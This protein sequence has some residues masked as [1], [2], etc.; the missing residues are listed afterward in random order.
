MAKK[1]IGWVDTIYYL[2]KWRKSILAVIL[3]VGILAA[4]LSPILPRWY[5]ASATLMPPVED[6]G[7][8]SVSSFVSKYAFSGG[9]LGLGM[10]SE[11]TSLLI[12]I[13]QS[14]IMMEAV[15]SEHDLISRYKSKNMEEAVRTLRDRTS[16]KVNEEGTITLSVSARTKILGGK[17]QADEAR[18]LARDMADTFIEKLDEINK[19]L[20]V[21]RARNTRIFI[22][23]RYQQNREDLR[24]AEETFK[25]Y[26]QKYG[27]IALNEQATATINAAAD[28]KTQIIAK[29]V[30]TGWLKNVVGQDHSEYLRAES[31][32]RVLEDKYKQFQYGKKK[33]ARGGDTK[34]DLF[35]P[36]ED[37]PELGI[38]YARLYRE[39]LMQEK[40]ME[41]LLPEFEQAKINEA[42]DTPTVQVLDNAVIPVAKSKPKRALFV[43]IAVMTALILTFVMILIYERIHMLQE[44]DR[45][46]YERLQEALRTVKTD[47]KLHKRKRIL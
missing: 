35:L 32:L 39:V 28:F 17:A 23:T 2:V 9:M 16:T 27:T 19:S 46:K 10:M 21:D 1:E 13:L 33:G 5:T 42:R 22:E 36:L 20:K 12:A 7:G 30:E 18:L 8:F 26:Q 45:D 40:I 24:A 41:F 43:V 47:L 11:E 29:E 14:R 37:V 3:I 6:T 4:G 31:E 44:L 25:A 15:I 34:N 38:E